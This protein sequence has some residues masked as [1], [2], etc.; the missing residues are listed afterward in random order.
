MGITVHTVRNYIRRSYEKLQVH[1]RTEAV[2]K[3][4]RH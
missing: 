1:S 2:A 3:F 4:S